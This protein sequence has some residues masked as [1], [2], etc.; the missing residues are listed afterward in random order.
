MSLSD[1]IG[2]SRSNKVA[3]L[4]NLD[5]RV[6]PD[7]DSEFEEILV[8]KSHFSRFLHHTMSYSGIREV[9][10]SSLSLSDLIG[11]SRLNQVANLF[12]LDYRVK[13]DNDSEGADASLKLEDDSLCAGRSMVEMLGV[14]AIIGVLSVGAIAGYSKAMSK[15]K[16]NK[17]IE[18][19]NQ[20]FA[21][22][23]TKV[24][25]DKSS[26]TDDGHGY[27]YY[28]ETM[29][30]AGWLP[31]GFKFTDTT[32]RYIYDAFNNMAWIFKYPAKAVGVGWSFEQNQKE[33]C[34]AYV[35]LAKEWRNDINSIYVDS[36]SSNNG[37]VVSKSYGNLYGDKNCTSDVKCLKDVTVTEIDNL[38]NNCEQRNC[39][40]Y[41]YF[42]KLQ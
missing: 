21:A 34:M 2:E 10:T 13:P 14:L 3:N 23:I 18:A 32:P 30:K 11:E 17:A 8:M 31:D 1:L 25:P 24:A 15:Y 41:F 16:L 27:V 42:N 9:F 28:T 20:L 29:A 26:L 7:N 33:L 40:F 37:S 4:F 39:R 19:A 5:Y 35:N 38:C 12:H 36:L 6:K 22:I